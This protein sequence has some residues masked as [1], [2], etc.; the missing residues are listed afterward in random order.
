MKHKI[1]DLYPLPPP[2]K[3]PKLCEGI[4]TP[5]V[6]DCNRI[7]RRQGL[8][9]FKGYRARLA[10][11]EVPDHQCGNYARYRVNG[12]YFCRKHAALIVLDLCAEKLE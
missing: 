1:E 7:R 9:R 12:K 4:L 3:R 6:A 8:K 10:K 11:A 2:F 5:Y